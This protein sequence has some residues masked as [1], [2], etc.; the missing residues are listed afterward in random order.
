MLLNPSTIVGCT[1]FNNLNVIFKKSH[2]GIDGHRFWYALSRVRAIF[3]GPVGRGL[4]A[5]APG[6]GPPDAACLRRR[7]LLHIA[8]A[9]GVGTGPQLQQ[10]AATACP[11]RV[12]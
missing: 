3:M 6:H 4:V 10:A 1:Q 7:A 11:G 5:L 8:D 9:V 2:S 12:E